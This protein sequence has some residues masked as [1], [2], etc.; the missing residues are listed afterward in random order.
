LERAEKFGDL[1]SAEPTR[2]V[3]ITGAARGLGKAFATRFAAAGYR[4]VA[5][6]RADMDLADER[7]ID[8]YAARSEIRAVDV[9][10]NNAAENVPQS[11]EDIET[12]TA[13]RAFQVNIAAPFAL[14]RHIGPYMAERGWGRIVNIASVYG[15]VSRPKRSMY[16]TAKS[17]IGGLT[18]AAAVELGPRNVLVN[19][20]APGFADTD[21][22]RQNNSPADIAALCSLVPLGRLAQPEEI[23]E[24]VFFLGSHHNTY[25]TGQTV[26][27]DGGFLCQ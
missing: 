7:S 5:P 1:I 20:V 23:A 16:S 19:A 14:V 10:I 27:I 8:A 13:A 17:A 6:S 12:A 2:T 21:L 24:L 3:L 11:L 9:L 15:I 4:V 25:V 22:T 18:R 26:A